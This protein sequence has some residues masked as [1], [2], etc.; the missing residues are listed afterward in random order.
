MIPELGH[1]ALILALCLAVTQAIVPLVGSYTGNNAWMAASRS[2]AWGQ[3]VF[4]TISLLILTNAF[5]SNDF[6]VVYVAQHGNTKL[7][8]IYKIS[9]VWGAHEGSLLLWAFLLAAWSVA[10]AAFSRNLPLEM[11]SR[12][13]AVM[14]MVSIGFMLFMLLT[15]N[16]F[17]RTFPVPL[18]GGELN[19][20]LQDP[21]LAI[22]PPMLYMG[23]V[24]FSVAFAFAIAALL[25]GRLDASWAR[26]SR[27]WTT[28]AW[29]FLTLGIVLGSWW[30][31]YELGWG[32][33]WFWDPVEN[34]SFMPWLVGT[35][36]IHSLAVTEKRGAFKSWTVLLAISAFSLSLLGTFLVRSGVLTSVHSFAS[37]PARGVFILIFLL[38]VIGGSLL[39]YTWRAPYISSG[40][41]F[42]LIS[43]ETFLLGNNLLLSVFAA[44]VLLGTLAPLIYD[45]LELGKISVG[46]PWFN[47]MFLLTT[48]FLALLMGIGSLSR[49]KHAE[50]SLL[51]KQLK[52]AFV[53]SV[54]FGLVSLLPMFSGGNWLVGLGMG[55]ALWVAASHIV[56]LRD[57]L[58]NKK[59]FNGFWQD[60]K[61]GGRSYYGMIVAH[62]GVAMFIV[63]VTMV[64]NF[65]EEHDVRMSPG[66]VSEIA[67]YEF[68]FDGVKRVPGPNYNAHRGSFQVSHNGEAFITLEP[69]K[70]T[71][72]VQTRPMTEAS[73]D[74]G[75]TRDLYVSLGE[76]LGG[77]DWSLRLYY[78]P[79]VRWI[80]LGGVLM[81]LGGILA[82]TD[83][84]YR[85]AKV[86]SPEMVNSAAAAA[87]ASG[88]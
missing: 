84:R 67:G 76:P 81:S 62:M 17:D 77:G 26:W 51:I 18:E 73:I 88:S 16:P 32:G 40:G 22:H 43:R 70:R 8:D 46:F 72:F 69:E 34:A 13:L 7:P 25:G 60:F 55:L 47:K 80:W 65:G 87:P 57:R 20:M 56:N 83:R 78:K 27:P 74:W 28:I 52:V 68:R 2:L 36:L 35:A 86:R 39:L 19:P 59:G 5:L 10:I 23:Y 4:L 66:D 79:Y 14:G 24:G 33:W 85:T 9:A 12:V 58:K 50:P 11:V 41:R 29:V 49:W 44:L 75:F 48:P 31:Y 42:D 1:F 38:I 15:S 6:S 71:Y 63:G 54:A 21:G 64:S 82:V 37:D 3:F 53:I 61:T 45:A 30:A